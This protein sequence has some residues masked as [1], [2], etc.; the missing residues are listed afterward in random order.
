MN[1]SNH[2]RRSPRRLLPPAPHYAAAIFAAAGVVL[3]AVAG[4]GSNAA[5]SGS[6]SSHASG[7]HL[8]LERE[9]SSFARCMRSHRVSDFPDPVIGSGGH[10]G[11]RLQGG[12]NSDLNP[13]NSAFRSGVEAC[14]RIL[15]H[16]FR[17]AFTPSGVGK[18]A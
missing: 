6:T 12:P 18:G 15:G 16:Q 1:D 2:A 13:N 3:L 8:Q 17:T 5:S 7:Q 14:Q 4:G 11:F 10:P 9:Y